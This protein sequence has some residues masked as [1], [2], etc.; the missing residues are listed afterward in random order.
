MANTINSANMLMPVPVVGTDPGPQYATDVNSC[1]TILDGH[2]HTPGY[3]VPVPTA[4][5]NI[6]T[7]LTFNQTNATNLRSVRFTP[8]GSPLA[9]ASDIGCL[10]EAGV[11]L[12]YNDGSGNQIQITS[13]GALAGTPGSI[14]GL[15]APASASYVTLSSTFVFKS[16]ATTPANLDGASFILRNLVANSK[17]LTL[18]PPAAMAA[19]Y[20]IT[21]PPL[22][23]G[24]TKFL[25]MDT[26]GAIAAVR[27]VDNSTIVVSSNLIQ[28][29]AGGITATQLAT[30]SVITV[31]IQDG[32]VTAA[33]LAA[34]IITNLTSTT[35][36]TA[37]AH[38]FT[39]PAGVTQVIVT[40][41][42]GSGGGG[43]GS[44]FTN[45]NMAGGGGGGGAVSSTVVLTV[46]PS[47]LYT[48]TVG[49]AG[50]AGAGGSPTG[51]P[52]T[53]GGNG[54]DTTFGSLWT[55][56]GASGGLHGGNNSAGT[57]GA[58]R[59]AN[60]GGGGNAANTGI[61]VGQDSFYANGGT[62]TLVAGTA[63]GGGGGAGDGAGG[64][65]GNGSTTGADTAGTAGTAGGGGGGGGGEGNGTNAASAGGAGT[66]GYVTIAYTSA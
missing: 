56:K 22:P 49:A 14:S 38:S 26:A 28:V 27:D 37:G 21:L 53:D 12:Y 6:N 23:T 2:N 35:Y 50:T 34:G 13:G 51:N 4:G 3:G 18:S 62:A 65:G 64:A 48:V 30:D 17:G 47:T 15:V 43:G 42:A 45:P 46:T 10:Y 33:K 32:A 41:R 31:K 11:D 57:G 59:L 7:D 1:L 8:Q 52:G 60:G 24:G 9:L 55:W 54:G 36:N 44:S 29:P 66:V 40:A 25:T 5:L 61:A 63:C 58:G 20:A 19:D 16:A 39:T